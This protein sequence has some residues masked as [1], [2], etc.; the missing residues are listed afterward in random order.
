MEK[1]AARYLL[2]EKSGSQLLDPVAQFHLNNGARVSRICWLADTSARGMD[3]S[4]GMMVNYRYELSEV[5]ENHE[6]FQRDGHIAA[7]RRVLRLLD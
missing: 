5:E 1:L 6:R 2:Q 4:Y 3:Q 7:A